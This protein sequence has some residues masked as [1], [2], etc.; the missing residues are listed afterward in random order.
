MILSDNTRGILYMNISMAA[1]TLNDILVK[2]VAMDLPLAQVMTIR[3][4]MTV[5]LLLCLAQI[6]GGF[7][8]RLPRR[9]G[10]LL[11]WRTLAEIGGTVTFLLALMQMPLAN[12]SAIMQSLPLAVTLAGAVFLREQIG[13]RRVSAILVGFIGVMFIV[14]PG[15][16]GFNIWSLVALASVAF[17][18][19]RD[20]VT[21]SFAVSVP[22]VVIAVWT[23]LA[24]MLTGMV[25]MFFEE[26]HPVRLVD[27]LRMGAASLALVLGYLFIVMAMRVG[28]VA[29][30]APFRY[31]ALLWAILAGWIAFGNLPGEMTLF[32]AAIIVISGLY[33]YLREQRLQRKL[34]ASRAALTGTATPNR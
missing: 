16:E 21:R 25:G 10:I 5:V 28:D 19:V 17:V 1:F 4:V 14:R 30:I 33:T 31:T 8:L 18:V 6:R 3:G 24:I 29:M 11:G 15:T 23:A 7:T 20:L 32:G 13:W 34:A 9:E 26:W 22:S 2:L 27:F 12:L